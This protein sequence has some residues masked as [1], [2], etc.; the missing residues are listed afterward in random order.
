LALIESQANLIVYG[1]CNGA[2]SKIFEKGHS[3]SAK[4]NPM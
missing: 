1:D 2:N 4:D 3:S